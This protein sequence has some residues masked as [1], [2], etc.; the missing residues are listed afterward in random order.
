MADI[1]FND[2]YRIPS[3]RLDNWNY[4]CPGPYFVTLCTLGKHPFFGE[5]QNGVMRLSPLGRIAQQYWSQIPDHFPNVRLDESII[6]PDH[7]H[8]IIAITGPSDAAK[9]QNIVSLL[10]VETQNLASL[11]KTHNIFGP[12]S[13]NLASIVRGYKIG[14]TNWARSHGHPFFM[15]QPRY[16]DH[17][18][19]NNDE[20]D[21]IRE[22]IRNNPMKTGV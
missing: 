1:L 10:H 21:R 19:R 6:M 17:I 7:V 11:P 13:R 4:G 22:Y 9:T 14:V 15:W 3:T 18:I 16:H 8:G 5:I 12:Q 20:L 2:R